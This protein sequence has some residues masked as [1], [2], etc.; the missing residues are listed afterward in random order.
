M[1]NPIEKPKASVP[2]LPPAPS[3]ARNFTHQIL[4]RKEALK[5]AAAHMTVF[6]DGTKEALHGHNYQVELN[7]ELSSIALS[8]LISFSVFKQTLRGIC[9]LWDEKVL[10]PA[11]CPYFEQ[12]R[13]DSQAAGARASSGGV[14]LGEEEASFEFR[15]CGRRYVLPA[16]EVVLL[17]QDNITA[18][19]LSA[20]LC[21]RLCR[22]WEHG[23]ISGQILAIQVR[24][25]ESPGQ[26][27]LAGW[28]APESSTAS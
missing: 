10:L 8:K 14:A 25:E 12:I 2:H 23:L 4:L 6:P 19:T 7:L 16:E 1:D 17:P 5:F 3:A 11:L 9:E 24:V 13:S 18:E 26:G 15:L 22:A 28:R 20:E 21:E 27:A